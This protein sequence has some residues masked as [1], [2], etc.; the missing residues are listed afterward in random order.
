MIRRVLLAV[1]ALVLPLLAMAPAVA[2]SSR[3][4]LVD[5]PRL[6]EVSGIAA[7]ARDPRFVY[8]QNDSG[9]SARFFAVDIRT[10]QTAAVYTVPGAR[11]VDWEDLAVAP[12]AAGRSSVWLADIGDNQSTRS[13]VDVY[14]IP[15]PARPTYRGSSTTAPVLATTRPD[16]WRLR[17]PDGPHD[18]ESIAV[19]PM[20]HRVYIATKS[21]SGVSEVFELPAR[22]DPTHRQPLSQIGTVTFHAHGHAGPFDGYGQFMA[23]GAAISPDGRLFVLRTYAD[24]YVWPLH[25]GDVQAA[26]RST[27]LR[28]R[29]PSQPQGEGV[30]V[31]GGA[32]W[33]SSEGRDQPI[34]TV[35]LP[36]A[37]L[38]A[39]TATPSHSPSGPSS[40]S[41][42]PGK[43]SSDSAIGWGLITI[44]AAAVM[45]FVL[46]SRL[47][48]RGRRKDQGGEDLSWMG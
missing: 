2:A 11:N 40:T 15:E 33:L 42:V 30:D 39:P 16:I 10:G 3:L 36:R 20:T 37:V 12:D 46:G 29:L 23:T 45:A 26:L 22:P 38:L 27:P 43:G 8:V 28:I 24:A 47:R 21:L 4:C 9:D 41:P 1:A 48:R 35:T 34:L 19:D 18:A 7:R 13:E 14:R 5:D 32:L 44:V 17:Y 31:V 25:D 6:S